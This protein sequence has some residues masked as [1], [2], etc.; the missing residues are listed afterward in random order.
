VARKDGTNGAKAVLQ[1]L[2]SIPP[3]AVPNVDR[4]APR[5]FALAH[6][7]VT[8]EDLLRLAAAEQAEAGR[9]G[10]EEFKFATNEEMFA[11]MSLVT[12]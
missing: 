11:A 9:R 4:L 3:R 1:Y 2:R 6:P 10:L 7:H 8:K 12:T 5:A